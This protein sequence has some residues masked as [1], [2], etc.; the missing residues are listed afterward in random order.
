MRITGYVLTILGTVIGGFTFFNALLVADSAP[1]Q[2]AGAAMAIAWAVLPY[3]FAR[4]IEK[5]SEVSIVT[6]LD[7]YF[8]RKET[9]PPAQPVVPQPR[10]R[11]A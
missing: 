9:P 10:T 2:A 5:I 11:P 3:C 4:A 6:V 8:D 7:R 1:Q